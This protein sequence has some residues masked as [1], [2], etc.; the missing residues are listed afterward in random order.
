MKKWKV[1]VYWGMTGIVELTANT[2]KEALEQANRREIALPVGSYLDGSFQADDGDI[3]MIRQCYNAN[4]PDEEPT[5]ISNPELRTA[6]KSCSARQVTEPCPDCGSEVTLF[7]EPERDGYQ[8]FCPVCGTKMM[9]CSM[10]PKSADNTCDW[11]RATDKEGRCSMMDKYYKVTVSETRYATVFVKADSP[12]KAE[13]KTKC[14]CC[15]MDL[16]Y[17]E[18]PIEAVCD[19]DY[20]G[21][22]Y[23]DAILLN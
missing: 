2:L 4:Q 14:I 17:D 3:E 20:K 19:R 16:E 18:M 8:I 9:L 15:C 23:T 13:E 11:S 10:C 6:P 21:F 22:P 12:E 1:P 5:A 7:W